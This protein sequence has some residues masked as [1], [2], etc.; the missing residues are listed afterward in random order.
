MKYFTILL[1]CVYILC[2][3]GCEKKRHEI[4]KALESSLKKM[5]D[6]ARFEFVKKRYEGIRLPENCFD[7]PKIIALCHAIIQEDTV[8]MKR[9]I[10][11]GADV[12]A[13]GKRGEQKISLLVYALPFG[14][15]VL[16][17]LLQHGADPN[18]EENVNVFNIA[19][20][21][22]LN[23]DPRY[24]NYLE[25]LLKYGANPE[26]HEN[27]SPLIKA[28]THTPYHEFEQEK[29]FLGLVTLVVLGTDLN[30]EAD[31]H[32]AVTEA[33]KFSSYNNL[34]YL[35]KCGA[36]YD[37]QTIPGGELQ[38]ILYRQYG[39]YQKNKK[40]LSDLKKDRSKVELVKQLTKEMNN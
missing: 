38:R 36:A 15:N 6:N 23:N 40:H 30:R 2:L 27:Y 24:K 4:G 1:L 10:L 17:C 13:I 3:A 31:G 39:D 20:R 29:P 16:R 32:Y 7:D 34:L 28:A 9:I 22:S 5:A 19:I 12:N 35:L 11:D 8:R 33:V 37:P 14:E 18:R 25:I 21:Y 26:S